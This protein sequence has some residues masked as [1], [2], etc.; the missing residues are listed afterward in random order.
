MPNL[1]VLA[2]RIIKRCA[3]VHVD[4]ENMT[5]RCPE[6]SASRLWSRPNLHPM[7]IFSGPT[8]TEHTLLN[9]VR[10]R[11]RVLVLFVCW[12]VG[13]LGGL[14]GRWWSV[15][16]TDD[17]IF[18]FLIS[19]FRRRRPFGRIWSWTQEKGTD[20][21]TKE[22]YSKPRFFTTFSRL[23]RALFPSLPFP[24]RT[25]VRFRSILPKPL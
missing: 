25:A 9:N 11:V 18:F 12:L 19:S 15:G 4:L 14:M 6:S 8:W 22:D 5:L 10:V 23:G 20:Q 13:W 1:L 3:F 17:P 24:M 16:W 21:V 7:V 2:P